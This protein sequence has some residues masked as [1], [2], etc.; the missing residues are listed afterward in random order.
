MKK[1][2]LRVKELAPE[3]DWEYVFCKVILRFF[4]HNI[5]GRYDPNIMMKCSS[6]IDSPSSTRRYQD[7][8][9]GAVRVKLQRS[10]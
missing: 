5:L 6:A 10:P 1:K 7:R 4:L 8:L 2:I 9:L 3:Q